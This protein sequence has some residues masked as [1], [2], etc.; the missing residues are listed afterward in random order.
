MMTDKYY[1]RS[2]QTCKNYDLGFVDDFT[3]L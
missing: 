1:K 2:F 3:D